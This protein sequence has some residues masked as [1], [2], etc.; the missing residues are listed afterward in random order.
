[1]PLSKIEDFKGERISPWLSRCKSSYQHI[2]KEGE[3]RTINI[4]G[5]NDKLEFS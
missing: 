5:I 3:N 1:M 2:L 4:G